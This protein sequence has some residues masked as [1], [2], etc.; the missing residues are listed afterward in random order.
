MGRGK[1]GSLGLGLHRTRGYCEGNSG[2]TVTTQVQVSV[3][4]CGLRDWSQLLLSKTLEITWSQTVSR[5]L[6]VGRELTPVATFTKPHPRGGLVL[7]GLLLI[8]PKEL[9]TPL[10]VAQ[11]HVSMASMFLSHE[12]PL[13]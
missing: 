12:L 6:G 7:L 1:I 10:L 4:D 2:I 8:D 11:D 9:D 13:G 5:A 3:R